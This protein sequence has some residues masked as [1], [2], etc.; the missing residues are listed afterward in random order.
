MNLRIW[1]AI[2]WGAFIGVLSLLSARFAVISEHTA[3]AAVQI[4]L[5]YLLTPGL[6]L[7]AFVGS[8]VPAACINAL[9]HFGLC[10]FLL[11]FVPR[12]HGKPIRE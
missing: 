2:L 8:L 6:I 12:I 7:A 3:L 11:R 5:T 10:F 4:V 9:T 1:I